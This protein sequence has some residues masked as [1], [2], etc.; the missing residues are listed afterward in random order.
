MT[1]VSTCRLSQLNLP[2]QLL[3]AQSFVR[4]EVREGFVLFFFSFLDPSFTLLPSAGLYDGLHY[5]CASLTHCDPWWKILVEN[6]FSLWSIS[7]EPIYSALKAQSIVHCEVCEAFIL[8]LDPSFTPL[9]LAGLYEGLHYLDQFGTIQNLQ[10]AFILKT[11]SC[12]GTIFWR[13]L[14]QTGSNRWNIL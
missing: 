9:P 2:T 11:S 7:A 4:R 3:E 12:S 13:F 6:L 1:L 5:V 8:F 10:G 14:Q